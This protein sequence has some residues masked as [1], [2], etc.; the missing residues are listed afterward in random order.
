MVAGSVRPVL[1]TGYLSCALTLVVVAAFLARDARSETTPEPAA[2][3]LAP[4]DA[5]TGTGTTTDTAE[6]EQKLRRGVN[7]A[8]AQGLYPIARAG[9][10]ELIRSIEQRAGLNSPELLAPLANLA[11]ACLELGD[12]DSANESVQRAL[13]LQD[14]SIGEATRVSLLMIAGRAA[15]AYGEGLR[16]RLLLEEA[17]LI[18]ER[19]KPRDRLTEAHIYELMLDSLSATSRES[20]PSIDH[21]EVLGNRYAGKLEGILKEVFDKDPGGL[22]MGLPVVADWYIRSGKV[23]RARRLLTRSVELL[24]QAYGPNDQRLSPSLRALAQCAFREHMHGADAIRV[25]TRAAALLADGSVPSTYEQAEALAMLGD[26]Q[27]VFADPNEGT[28]YYKKAWEAL[29]GQTQ[30]GPAGANQFFARP[31]SLYVSLSAPIAQRN[32]H[33]DVTTKLRIEFIVTAT[34]LVEQPRT[35]QKEG[36]TLTTWASSLRSSSTRWRYRPRVV[37]GAPVETIGETVDWDFN[38]YQPALL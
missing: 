37:D 7:A 14:G 20:A 32:G 27:V 34:G 3:T 1:S 19:G 23:E 8:L 21:I 10:E 30:I 17:L 29:A 13:A 18:V 6:R 15:T 12:A 28:G 4:P 22:G 31:L 26:T 16:A 35:V 36:A 2:N 11:S 5:G 38:E 25:L 24:E 33:Q 9:A